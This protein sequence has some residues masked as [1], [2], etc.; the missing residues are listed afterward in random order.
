MPADVFTAEEWDTYFD[1]VRQGI[2]RDLA[3]RAIGST[4]SRIRTLIRR[5][6]EYQQRMSEAL[7]EADEHYRDRLRA[8]VRMEALGSADRPPNI[9]ALE[10]ELATHGG[11]EYAH[12]RRDRVKHEGRVE[13]A[14]ILDATKLDALDAEE[15]AALEP[16]FEKLAA[17]EQKALPPGPA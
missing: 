1:S 5:D 16:V 13:H 17:E 7:A 12:L 8:T 15:L 2:G 11:P 9:R 10:V 14:L 4:G 3:A 6:P